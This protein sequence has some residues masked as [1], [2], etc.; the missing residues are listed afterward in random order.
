MYILFCETNK[1]N[2][3][4]KEIKDLTHEVSDPFAHFF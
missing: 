3:L 1:K 2:V 4:Q